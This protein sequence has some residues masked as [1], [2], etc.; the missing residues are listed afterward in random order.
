MSEIT[1]FLE[2]AEIAGKSISTVMAPLIDAGDGGG[3]SE[4]NNVAY[5]A[6]Q[7]KALFLKLYN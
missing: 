4:M 1:E 2:K 7:L 3:E 5:E 6:R